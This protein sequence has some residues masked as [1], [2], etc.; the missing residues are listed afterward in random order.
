MGTTRIILHLTDGIDDALLQ[1]RAA[2]NALARGIK[3]GELWGSLFE[4]GSA[5]SIQ[6][7]ASGSITVRPTRSPTA[8]EQRGE[9]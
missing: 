3:A 6:R 1:V 7:N 2:K 4:D 5:F 9:G 8:I